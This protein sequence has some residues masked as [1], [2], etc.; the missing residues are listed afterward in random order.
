[1]DAKFEKLTLRLLC[2]HEYFT[3]YK[4]DFYFVSKF[5]MEKGLFPIKYIQEELYIQNVLSIY[6]TSEGHPTNFLFKKEDN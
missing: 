5:C 6:F 3:I 2:L 4:Q 1:M